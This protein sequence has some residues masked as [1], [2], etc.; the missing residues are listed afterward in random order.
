MILTQEKDIYVQ[1]LGGASEVGATCIYIYWKGKK[2]LIDSGKRRGRGNLYPIFDEISKE[3]DLFILTHVHQ[4]HIGS[5]MEALDTLNIKKILTSKENKEII[6]FIL[7]DTQKII[8]TNNKTNSKIEELYLDENIEKSIKN[9]DVLDYGKKFNLAELTIA[10]YE[11]SHLL[12][13]FGIFFESKDYKLLL[14]SDFTESQKFFHPK[15]TFLENLSG[16]DIDTIITETTYGNNLDGDEVLKENCLNDLAYAIN[17]VFKD[18]GNILIPCFAVG[19]MQEVILA[20]LKLIISA[21][22]D[23]DTKIYIPYFKNHSTGKIMNL[24]GNITDKYFQ[25]YFNI[26][27]KEL[28]LEDKKYLSSFKKE[29]NQQQSKKNNSNLEKI[30]RFLNIKIIKDLS[31]DFKNN[32]KSIFLIQPGMLASVYEKK[33]NF[34]ISSKLAL[35]IMSGEKNGIIFVGYQAQ[36]T[37]G[38]K[39]KNSVYNH[40]VEVFEKKYT[41]KNKNIYSVSFPGHVSIM[42]V[43]NLVEKLKPENIILVHGDLGASQNMAKGITKKNILIPEIDEKIYLMDNDKKLFF[44]MQHKFSKIIVDFNNEYILENETDN[45]IN[46]DK[47]KNYKIVD[48]LKKEYM[49]KID[50]RLLSLEFIVEDKKENKKTI[51]FYQKL[52]KDLKDFGITSNLNM[53]KDKNLLVED[54]SK[55]VSDTNEKTAIYIIDIPFETIEE[56]II[57]SQ[58]VDVETYFYNEGKIEEVLNFPFDIREDI[59]I[60]L[61]NK[62]ELEELIEKLKYYHKKKRKKDLKKVE[63]YVQ[64]PKYN[65]DLPIYRK[66]IF[67]SEDR[68]L[69]GDIDSLL[70][71]KN[72]AVVKDLENI[73]LTLNQRI[74]NI[75]LTNYEYSYFE[76]KEYR[77]IIGFDKNKIYGKYYLESG[78]QFFVINLKSNLSAE[79][80]IDEV[81]IYV[82]I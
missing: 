19:R 66:N 38:E 72:K 58:M 68:S 81:K 13:S 37:V 7:K 6:K 54:I 61:K 46:N 24:G 11:T 42:G 44:S 14:T 73:Y 34:L 60:D 53:I 5:F 62:I 15:T 27:V 67:Y 59:D 36:G 4:D 21:E 28:D 48:L 52:E 55:L 26:L 63:K 82:E 30:M 65:I 39:I 18:D 77:E 80:L 3:I 70:D 1:F 79:N 50:T 41:R 23:R 10:F 22:I 47:Y 17:T 32:K 25:E 8:E 78:I 2:I 12:G 45:I 20:I 64:R 74:E 29:L 31:K 16:E 71:V 56:F 76:N 9:V 57:I 35:D 33:E 40:E 43:V 51:D 69:W 49:E 75:Q